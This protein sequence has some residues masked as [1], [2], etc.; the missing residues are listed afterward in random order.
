MKKLFQGDHVVQIILRF[1]L[2]IITSFRLTGRLL[3][4]KKYLFSVSKTAS[5]FQP[6]LHR[7][8]DLHDINGQFNGREGLK[9]LLKRAMNTTFI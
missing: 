8:R 6:K 5:V 3:S 1:H 9:P 7:P 4:K 2:A